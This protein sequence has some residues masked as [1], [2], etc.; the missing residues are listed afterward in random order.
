VARRGRPCYEP[1][2]D[3]KEQDKLIEIKHKQSG[4]VLLRVDADTLAGANLVGADLQG[5]DLQISM[6]PRTGCHM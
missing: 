1:D 3:R 5:A 2:A 4:A 6:F